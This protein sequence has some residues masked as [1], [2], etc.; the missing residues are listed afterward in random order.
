MK[1]S[2]STK[3]SPLRPFPPVDIST[4]TMFRIS[5]LSRNT[6]IVQPPPTPYPSDATNSK[7][8]PLSDGV[9]KGA[10]RTFLS[11]L[12]KPTEMM[13]ATCANERV[14]LQTC[15]ETKSAKSVVS[16][17]IVKMNSCILE[18]CL[19]FKWKKNFLHDDLSWI[20]ARVSVLRVGKTTFK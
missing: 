7:T 3:A 4:P 1:I 19:L 9:V 20:T 14:K 6:S 15:E 11:V 5:G 13:N 16:R 2:R 18:K 12:K 17:G 8:P 10:S